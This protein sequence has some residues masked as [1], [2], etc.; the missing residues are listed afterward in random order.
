MMF[1][2]MTGAEEISASGTSYL[3]R[4]EAAAV[5]K[6]VT[7]F[8]RAGVAPEA[9]GVVTPYEGQRA[10]VVQHMTRAGVLHPK[11]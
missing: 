9:I 3:N 4:T 11:P 7:H 8:L 2:S 5:E 10:Y 6:L 1:W